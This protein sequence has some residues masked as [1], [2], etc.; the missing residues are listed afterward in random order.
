M[1]YYALLPDQ[2]PVGTPVSFSP[3]MV[4]TRSGLSSSVLLPHRTE[5]SKTVSQ[6]ALCAN[7]IPRT[8]ATIWRFRTCMIYLPKACGA[9]FPGLQ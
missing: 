5:P 9:T 4:P 2:T 6:Y 1:L 3:V 7:S 8:E